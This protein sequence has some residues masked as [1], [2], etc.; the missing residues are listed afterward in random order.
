MFQSTD[1]VTLPNGDKVCG[2]CANYEVE[3][4]DESRRIDFVQ[5]CEKLP[6]PEAFELWDGDYSCCDCSRKFG[7]IQ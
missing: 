7:N 3:N 4:T 5:S 6:E 2:D 1:I